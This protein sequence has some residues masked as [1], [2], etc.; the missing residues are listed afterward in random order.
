MFRSLG[1][2]HDE[3]RVYRSLLDRAPADAGEISRRPDISTDGA[4]AALAG[5]EAKF[6]VNRIDSRGAML[7]I[8]PEVGLTALINLR[9]AELDEASQLVGPLTDH[10]R[11]GHH[12]RPLDELVELCVGREAV[13]RRL[14]H[15]QRSVREQM[16]VLV[17]PPYMVLMEDMTMRMLS[18]GKRIRAVYHKDAIEQ[19]G[20]L[21]AIQGF[22][23]AGEEARFSR[24]LPTKLVIADDAQAVMPV[25]SDPEGIHTT[26]LVVNPSGLLDTLI[27]MFEMIWSRARPLGV[28]EA[29]KL[30]VS[31]ASRL[32]TTEQA[33]LAMLINGLTDRA[34]AR[35]LGLSERT[36]QRRV[37]EV[38]AM[39]EAENRLQLGWHL[40]QQ[41]Q[42]TE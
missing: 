5:L 32:S 37:H 27:A 17:R 10:Y 24:E 40:G 22:V 6:L 12:E 36:V 13:A 33:I 2:T 14:E 25:H 1:V 26:C 34:A 38:M 28:T 35:E 23:E 8:S 31:G 41:Q 16:R 11:H 19:P 15:V 29:R 7:P 9:R 42:P 30:R 39:V 18:E 4:R 21:A 3:E 20:A